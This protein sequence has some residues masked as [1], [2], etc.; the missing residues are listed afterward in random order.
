MSR[1]NCDAKHVARE[2]IVEAEHAEFFDHFDL[3][4]IL[5]SDL[6]AKSYAPGEC[7]CFNPDFVYRHR[8]VKPALNG[9]TR[10]RT[11]LDDKACR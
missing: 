5:G 11:R 6:K 2:A 1:R 10:P 8:S 7:L 4:T 3:E 9:E